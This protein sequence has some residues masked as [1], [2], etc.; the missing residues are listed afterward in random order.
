MKAGAV[1]ALPCWRRRDSEAALV[2]HRRSRGESK[3]KP[4]FTPFSCCCA[5]AHWIPPF[6]ERFSIVVLVKERNQKYVDLIDLNL[7]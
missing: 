7:R 2:L 5:A 6:S 1:A 4:H 3:G